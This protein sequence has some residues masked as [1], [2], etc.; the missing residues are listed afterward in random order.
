VDVFGI[1]PARAEGVSGFRQSAAAI[2]AAGRVLNAHAWSTAV[3]TAASLHLS[4]ASPAARLFELKPL[5]GPMQFDLVDEPFWHDAGVVRAPQRP[6]HGAEPRLSV[7]ERYR[8][9]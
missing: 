1:D 6:G 2:E 5:P 9:T 4:L 3:L 8:V 7:I